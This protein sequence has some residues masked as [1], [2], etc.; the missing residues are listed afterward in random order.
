MSLAGNDVCLST[1]TSHP[2]APTASELNASLLSE[3]G[4][5]LLVA[6]ALWQIGDV[7]SLKNKELFE[8]DAEA[9]LIGMLLKHAI[10]QGIKIIQLYEL[11]LSIY[12]CI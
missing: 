7:P 11:D 6:H 1:V 9:L 12:L 8:Y 3:F 4:E 2:I 5:I 10:Y